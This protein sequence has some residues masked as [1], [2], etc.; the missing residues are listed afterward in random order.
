[1]LFIGGGEYYFVLMTLGSFVSSRQG[2]GVCFYIFSFLS[3]SDE[4]VVVSACGQNYSYNL[5]S[6]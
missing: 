2:L 5:G 6:Y 4:G 1:M 3:D